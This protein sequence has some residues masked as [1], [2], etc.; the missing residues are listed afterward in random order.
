MTAV[1]ATQGIELASQQEVA[2]SAG[3]GGGITSG[4]GFSRMVG[5]EYGAAVNSLPD[6]Q[7]AAVRAYLNSAQGNTSPPGYKYRCEKIHHGRQ[8]HG[9]CVGRAYPDVAIAGHAFQVVI[10]GSVRIIDGTSAAAPVFAAM[11]SNVNA[12]RGWPL[13]WLNPALYGAHTGVFNDI[14]EGSNT[15]GMN[16]IASMPTVC[17]AGS[18]GFRAGPG[19]DPVTGLGSVDYPRFKN[20]M[21]LSG[22]GQ[23][24]TLQSAHA[25]LTSQYYEAIETHHDETSGGG[26]EDSYA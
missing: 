12:E 7:S 22:G 3:S 16:N 21:I 20:L 4:G 15:D 23:E 5:Q 13:G 24:D 1:G 26:Q 8:Y 10:G 2:C 6:W 19:W 18:P 9:D 11:V 17:P 14:T 25:D